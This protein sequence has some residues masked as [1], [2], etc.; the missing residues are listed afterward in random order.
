MCV[1]CC[2]AQVCAGWRASGGDASYMGRCVTA[3]VRYVPSFSTKLE[4]DA[5]DD[6]WQAAWRVSTAADAWNEQHSLPADPIWTESDWPNE[7]PD[8]QLYLHE[9]PAVEN[10]LLIAGALVT[11]VVGAASYAAR[12]AFA[13]HQ[14]AWSQV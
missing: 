4:C 9:S 8:L 12:V 10:G 7:I 5:C 3:T 1:L 6:P 14:A 13:R 2:A 11:A